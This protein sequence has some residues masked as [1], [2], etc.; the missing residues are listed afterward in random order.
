[1]IQFYIRNI[2]E[3]NVLRMWQ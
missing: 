2:C 1:M 3:I